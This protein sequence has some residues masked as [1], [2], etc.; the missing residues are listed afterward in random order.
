MIVSVFYTPRLCLHD[1]PLYFLLP[2][3]TSVQRHT[4]KSS[5]EDLESFPRSTLLTLFLL[6]TPRLS[7]S[8][9]DRNY[10]FLIKSSETQTQ[11]LYS[12][13]P[14]KLIRCVQHFDGFHSE[15][16]DK[17]SGTQNEVDPEQGHASSL[18]L[19]S[20]KLSIKLCR[21]EL[22][23]LALMLGIPLGR[24]QASLSLN[25]EGAFGISLS[26]SQ[27]KVDSHLQLRLIRA[28]RRP[29]HCPSKG[30]GYTFLFAKYMPAA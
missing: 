2:L 16:D 14:R 6:G 13:S 24:H 25:G 11:D 3:F 1:E 27:R 30:S 23:G 12:Q 4:L 5:S 17:S 19:L 10:T 26:A 20:G 15:L 18:W 21:E 7:F 9:S 29:R 28:E 22:C 8:R